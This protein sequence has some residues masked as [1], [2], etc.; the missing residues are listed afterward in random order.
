MTIKS[1]EMRVGRY[2]IN[3]IKRFL[4]IVIACQMRRQTFSL[5]VVA[6]EFPPTGKTVILFYTVINYRS[7]AIV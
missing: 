6:Y 4:T 2:I 3:P 1:F 7:R 5:G